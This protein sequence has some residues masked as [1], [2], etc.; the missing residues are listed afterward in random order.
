MVRIRLRRVGARH[1]P[2]YRI[3]AADKESPRDGKFLEVLGHYNPRTEP[4][5]VKVDEARLFHWLKNGAQPSDA[6]TK[7]LKPLGTWERWD[8]FKGG[9]KLETLLAEA[10]STL[11]EVDPRTRRDD[12]IEERLKKKTKKKKKKAKEAPKAE[13]KEETVAEAKEAEPEVKE[14]AAE[15]PT[16]EAVQEEVSEEAAPE[17]KP[18]PEAEDT[19][20]AIAS[21]EE[22]AEEG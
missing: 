21:D 4:S 14:E 10:E 20:E 5:T 2:S 13:A 1:Q 9:E 19:S 15:E 18:E 16:E 11:S 6:V 17:E 8:R 7:V 3:V 12:L 22:E